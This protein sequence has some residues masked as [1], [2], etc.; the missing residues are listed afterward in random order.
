MS[1]PEALAGGR[2]LLALDGPVATVT[3]NRP[4]RR[5]AL[6]RES[7]RALRRAFDDFAADDAL[8]VAVL[9]GAGG[10]FC[11]G[12]DLKELAAGVDYE[13]WAGSEA[14]PTHPLLA[15]PVIAAIAGTACAGGLGLA[16]WCDLRVCDETAVFGVFSRRWG[17]PMSDGT[18]VRLPRLIGLS[19]ALDMLLTGRPVDAR[20]ALAIGLANR[21]VPAGGALGEAQ[22]MARRIAAFPQ[23]AMRSDRESA[24]RQAD[25]PLPEAIAEEDRLAQAARRLEARAGAERFAAGAGRHGRD[26]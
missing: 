25:L 11:A 1:A 7:A 19:R 16:L 4:E 21:V 3:I 18:T 15:K 14:G 10:S 6:D 17:V 24:Y 12:A 23:V 5:N 26:A 8:K 9:T 13:A 2:I 20:E 22:A